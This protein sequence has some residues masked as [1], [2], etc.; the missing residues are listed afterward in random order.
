MTSA[1][2]QFI[3]WR[4]LNDDGEH[5]SEAAGTPCARRGKERCQGRGQK[6]ESWETTKATMGIEKKEIE[7]PSETWSTQGYHV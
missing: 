5:A 6:K 1:T 7:T 3:G 2:C 4:G